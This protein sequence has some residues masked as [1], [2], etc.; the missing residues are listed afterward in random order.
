LFIVILGPANKSTCEAVTAY[1]A[2]ITCEAVT[3]YEADI[4]CEAVTANEAVPCKDPVKPVVAITD[5]V[6]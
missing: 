1:E 4:T 2:D 5:P 3:A 6:T